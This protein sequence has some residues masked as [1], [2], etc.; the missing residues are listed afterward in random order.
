MQEDG[1]LNWDKVKRIRPLG[2]RLLLKRCV[3]ALDEGR[4]K[5]L[6]SGPGKGLAV[7]DAYADTC[8]MCEIIEVSDDC[9][10]FSH[11]HEGK[12]VQSPEWSAGLECISR[13]LELWMA[14]EDVLPACVY[15]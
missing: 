13:K 7:P 8:N 11:D 12:F 3:Q 5:V 4:Y 1:V 10:I 15:E 14:M 9:E 2:K 6:Q